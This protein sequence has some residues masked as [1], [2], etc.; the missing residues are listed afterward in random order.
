MLRDE[1]ADGAIQTIWRGFSGL[2]G[3]V[4]KCDCGC[5]DIQINDLMSFALIPR[6]WC[7]PAT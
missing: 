6:N 3:G 4:A 2:R 5:T 1:H 7:E